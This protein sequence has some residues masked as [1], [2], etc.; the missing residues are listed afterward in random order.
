VE[1]AVDAYVARA[2]SGTRGAHRRARHALSTLDIVEIGDAA[3]R[4]VEL[5]ADVYFRVSTQLGIR[6]CATESQRCRKT[7]IGCGSPKARCSTTCR[8]C[9]AR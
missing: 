5:V 3:T 4:P 1:A 9:S 6:G 7:S 2:R 8:V